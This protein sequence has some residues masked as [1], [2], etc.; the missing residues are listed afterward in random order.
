MCWQRRLQKSCKLQMICY[1]EFVSHIDQNASCKCMNC[2]MKS[3]QKMCGFAFKMQKNRRYTVNAFCNITNLCKQFSYCI[4]Q[5][6]FQKHNQV[7][8]K[9]NVTVSKYLMLKILGLAC[10]PAENSDC[11]YTHTLASN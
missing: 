8:A 3:L 4:F 7:V 11:A 2:N 9:S 1:I 6:T 10:Y 5:M